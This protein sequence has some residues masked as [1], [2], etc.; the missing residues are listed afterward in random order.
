M[1]CFV[2]TSFPMSGSGLAS[3][4][5]KSFLVTL[6][7]TVLFLVWGSGT[8]GTAKAWMK[9]PIEKPHAFTLEGLVE[10]CPNN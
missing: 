10:E 4:A 1:H 2:P 3:V 8:E 7:S 9:N 6:Y 5:Y